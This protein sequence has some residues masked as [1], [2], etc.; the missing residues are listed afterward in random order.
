MAIEVQGRII[1]T[2]EEGYLLNL[3]DWSEEV[4][5]AIANHEG[6][7]LKDEHMGLIDYCRDYYDEHQVHPTM[8]VIV[9]TL[10]RNIGKRFHDH[11]TYSEWLYKLFPTDPISTLCKL[12]GL[13]K[14][15]PSEH[16][17]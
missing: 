1:E 7:E 10:G 17:G 5:E 6:V 4:S 9:Q 15:L 3:D 12:A 8:H 14:P 11:K 2:D 13:P 16:D